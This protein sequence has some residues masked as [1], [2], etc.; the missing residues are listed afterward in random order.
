M[1]CKPQYGMH[2]LSI[3]LLPAC[4][5]KINATNI[6][7]I[8]YFK[9]KHLDNSRKPCYNILKIINERIKMDRIRPKSR[10]AIDSCSLTSEY[11]IRR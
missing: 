11:G 10:F 4:E 8:S 7:K 3:H 2:I 1:Y 9:K 5:D 6:K